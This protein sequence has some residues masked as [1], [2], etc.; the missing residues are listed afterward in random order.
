MWG[1]EPWRRWQRLRSG[2]DFLNWNLPCRKLH[3]LPLLFFRRLPRLGKP[4]RLIRDFFSRV[5]ACWRWSSLSRSASPASGCNFFK[6]VAAAG[7]SS[8][9]P[10]DL[11]LSRA[12]IGRGFK[13]IRQRLLPMFRPDL[14]AIILKR[15]EAPSRRMRPRSR[16]LRSETPARRRAVRACRRARAPAARCALPPVRHQPGGSDRRA[17]PGW[18]RA[19]R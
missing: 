7:I 8:R 11:V 9:R 1:V 12:Q 18:A 6:Q 19:G 4:R 15:R 5:F 3:A 2:L 10:T 17:R 14:D 13:R 16:H